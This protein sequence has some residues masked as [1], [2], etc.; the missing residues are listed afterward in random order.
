MIMESEIMFQ[1][2]I[3]SF[4]QFSFKNYLSNEAALLWK[5]PSL[6]CNLAEKMTFPLKRLTLCVA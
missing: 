3:D 2:L 6:K 5:G 1:S 4:S